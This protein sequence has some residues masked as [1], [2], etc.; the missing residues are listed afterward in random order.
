M[1]VGD[2]IYPPPAQAELVFSHPRRSHFHRWKRGCLAAIHPGVS[3]QQS[4]GIIS[5]PACSCA[6]PYLPA[7]CGISLLWGK[8]KFESWHFQSEKQDITLVFG[9]LSHRPEM[10]R[11]ATVSRNI[12]R[13]SSKGAVKISHLE[14]Q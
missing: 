5:A 6:V 1:D 3:A 8:N 11:L 14:L 2:P 12:Q 4:A 7:I 13:C 10:E 9:N